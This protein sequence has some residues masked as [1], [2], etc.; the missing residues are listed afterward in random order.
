VLDVGSSVTINIS[1]GTCDSDVGL[2]GRRFGAISRFVCCLVVVV[3]LLITIRAVGPVSAD[4]PVVQP[5]PA[6]ATVAAGEIITVSIV[7][8]RAQD[9]YGIDVRARFDPSVVEVVDADSSL[10]GIQLAS[11]VF[12]TPDFVVRNAADNTNGT[13]QYAITQINPSEPASGDGVIVTV[14]LRGLVA[15]RQSAFT[16][17]SILL[18]NRDGTPL[19]ATATNGVITV[20]GS[21]GQTPATTMTTVL[22][23]T[24]TRTPTLATAT[25]SA[26]PIPPTS[27]PTEIPPPSMARRTSTQLAVPT[28]AATNTPAS[29][30]SATATA[31]QA[32]SPI[33]TLTMT[34]RLVVTETATAAVP[35][36]AMTPIL[37]AT[38]T[39]I[40]AMATQPVS[41]AGS[42]TPVTAT[43]AP[44]PASVSVHAAPTERSIPLITGQSRAFPLGPAPAA[45][46]TRGLPSMDAVTLL[47]AGMIGSGLLMLAGLVY[48]WRRR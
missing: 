2:S 36:T 37:T 34:P 13:I 3:A 31:T 33:A 22:T 14:A 1:V 45:E 39:R 18:A 9:L 15:G 19:P 10:A 46:S 27:T 20:V 7:V 40:A 25:V 17:E 11:G 8:V 32:L 6:N 42:D 5:E 43:P 44:Q 16:I 12:L 4:V 41:A 38:A 24:R 26:T 29:V 30:V 48:V 23:A 28:S 47:G 21:N 35:R